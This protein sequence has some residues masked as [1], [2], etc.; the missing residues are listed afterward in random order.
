MPV[1][2]KTIKPIEAEYSA[3]SVSKQKR[4]PKK[5]L[6]FTAVFFLVT[7]ILNILARVKGFCDFYT[8]RVFG[9]WAETY[10]RL[11]SLFTFSVG[12]ILVGF[13]VCTV[14]A[15]VILSVLLIFLHKK[16]RYLKFTV[17]YL[18]SFLI[19]LLTTALVMTLNCS[20]PY[21]CS[22]LDINGHIDKRYTA[23]ELRILR[24]YIVTQCNTLCPKMERDENHNII[25]QDNVDIEIKQALSSLQDEYPR[26]RG[27]YPNPKGMF[28]SYFMYQ[29]QVIGV[30]FP[31]SMEANYTKYLSSSYYPNVAAHELTHLK[32]YMFENE[33]NFFSY[34]ACTGSDNDYIKYSGYLSVLYFVD[35]DYKNCVDD[36]TYSKQVQI[37][38]NVWFDNYCYDEQTIEYLIT[39]E[40]AVD[41]KVVESFSETLTDTYLEYYNA[42]PNYNEVTLLLLQYYDG[43]LY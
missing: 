19:F 13:A 34:L 15:A 40:H 6:I 3:D 9:I 26:F 22:K 27:Y 21:G 42:E 14:I 7:V 25:K 33:A 1:L 17:T 10:G 18:K 38:N 37:T 32:G 20:I 39:K 8:D 29:A 36:E 30:Y 35:D 31:F 16:K 41:D 2:E 24:E 5:Y 23:E 4:K 11:T 43:I 28:G 12:E